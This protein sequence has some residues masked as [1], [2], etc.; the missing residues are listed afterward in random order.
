M[1]CPRKIWKVKTEM[2]MIRI[3]RSVSLRDEFSDRDLRNRRGIDSD[4]DMVGVDDTG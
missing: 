2:R 4:L 3:I 1:L